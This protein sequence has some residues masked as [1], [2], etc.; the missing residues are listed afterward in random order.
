MDSLASGLGRTVLGRA[1]LG[2]AGLGRAGLGRAVLG[3]A[4]MV[5]EGK[6]PDF[7]EST[8]EV[9]PGKLRIQAVHERFSDQ[10]MTMK[11]NTV[12]DL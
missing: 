12:G 3:K 2:R 8:L 11:I 1:G 5:V 10:Y 7:A 6:R 4:Q 9:G